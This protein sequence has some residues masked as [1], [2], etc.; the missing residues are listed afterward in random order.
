MFQYISDI[1]LEYLTAIPDIRK[2]ANNLI[3]V[4]DIGHPGTFLFNKFLKKCS[5]TYKN[6]FLVY[7]NHEYYSILRGRHKK[8][9]TMQQKLDY[10]KDFPHNV[11]FLNNS[12]VYYHIYNETVH[13]TLDKL[14]NKKNYVKIIGST[15]W[16]DRGPGANN[17]KNIFIE[18]DKL[19]TFEYQCELFSKSKYY[20]INE[21][22]KED[23]ES[24]ILTHYT[25][26]M[27]S[28]SG[29]YLDNKDTNNIREL[30]LHSK[31][32][33]CINGHTHSYINTIAPGTNIKLLA[34]CFGYKS[35]DKNVVK[36]NENATLELN[37]KTPVSFSGLYSTSE[38]NPIDI[39]YKVMNRPNPI[40][41][42]G[43]VDESTAFTIST[44]TKD[45][46]IVYANRSFEK[47]TGYHLSNIRGKNGRFMQSPTGEVKRGTMREECDNQLLFNIKTKLSKKE[48][49]QFIT[50]NFR[51]NKD[52]FINLMTIVPI[53][54]NSVDYFV[55]FHCD[56]SN[57][58]YKF[59]L[60]K[61]DNLD[62]SIID[63]NII[64]ELSNDSSILPYEDS[65][66][67]ASVSFSATIS[68]G[69]SIFSGGHDIGINE[70][71]KNIR[72]KHFFDTNPSFLCIIDK[73]GYFK[74]INSTFLNAMDYNKRDMYNKILLDFI[75]PEDIALT[76]KS[77]ENI[78][79]VK[80]L[81]TTNR[82]ITKHGTLLQIDWISRMKGNVIYCIGTLTNN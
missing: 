37:R 2:T 28:N 4:G 41:N 73:K 16:S 46:A 6:I 5:E 71:R 68:D 34:N 26:H 64:K 42:I 48:E 35:E 20:L 10:A 15:L 3:L 63:C 39:L 38:I 25:T 1:H 51:K 14:D 7:G 30:Y 60:D 65:T 18:K 52:K 76:I 62:K 11:Y 81:S 57:E 58:I 32:I 69:Y 12:C 80:E 78:Q 82:Y 66:D 22:Y 59:N 56:V 61:L 55:G 27:C 19:L 40:Y 23:I 70:S 75:H 79:N 33:A 74:K 24:I 31:L 36:Y 9:E 72:Y 45:H 77:N 53:N 29:A 50:Y 17:F 54:I 44:M 13:F 8:I 21:L 47:L 67:T 43:Q 49:C